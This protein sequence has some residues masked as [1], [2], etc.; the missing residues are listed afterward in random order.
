MNLLWSVLSVVAELL[1]VLLIIGLIAKKAP[2]FLDSFLS[3][4]ARKAIFVGFLAAL[5]ATLGSLIYSDVIGY[6]P[7]KLCWYQR[8][9]MYPLVLVL[10]MAL[11]KKH[12]WI[13]PYGILLSVVGALIAAFHYLGQIGWN[14]LGLECLAIGYSTSCAKN[15]VL[16]F[17]YITIPLMAFSAF[18][19]IAL[20]LWYSMKK[21]KEVSITA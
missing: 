19:L 21:D 9:F 6:E 15:F 2:A 14:P 4:I 18:V 13:K 1:S 20:S 10:G 17:G 12:E 16:E 5:L 8:I 7:C 3:F 11:W